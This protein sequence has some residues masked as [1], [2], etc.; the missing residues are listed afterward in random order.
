MTDS[1]PSPPAAA[2]S[3]AWWRLPIVWL[4]IGGP[5]TVVVAALATAVI[6]FTGADPVVSEPSSA[7]RAV[8][9]PAVQARNHGAAPVP[10]LDKH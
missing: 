8:E 7:R 4:V 6:A 9:V 10:A 1:S 5:A 3:A 2:R